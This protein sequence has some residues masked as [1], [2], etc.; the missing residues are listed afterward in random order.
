MVEHARLKVADASRQHGALEIRPGDR[1]T[2]Q[3][4]DRTEQIIEALTG[5]IEAMPAG[6]EAGIEARLDGLD[7]GG[8]LGQRGALEPTQHLDVAPLAFAAAGHELALEQP[9]LGEQA[10][11]PEADRTQTQTQA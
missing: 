9:T 11:E 8:Q 5:L 4:L 10:L 6:Q 3:L 2:L 7:L 1:G